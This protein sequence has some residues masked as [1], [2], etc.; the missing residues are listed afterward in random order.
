M[1]V[2]IEEHGDIFPLSL[3]LELLVSCPGAV[4]D[5]PRVSGNAVDDAVINKFA[6]VIEHTSVSRFS[7]SD[8]LDISGCGFIDEVSGVRSDEVYFFES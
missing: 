3:C 7:W 2:V 8:F 6:G 5:H 4:Y 1:Q